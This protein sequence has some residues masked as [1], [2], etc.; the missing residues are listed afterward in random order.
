MLSN[1]PTHARPA[2]AFEQE[3]EDSK[4]SVGGKTA[5]PPKFA[6]TASQKPKYKN[7][8]SL[9]VGPST[10]TLGDFPYRPGEGDTLWTLAEEFYFEPTYWHHI[11]QANKDKCHDDGR[12]IYTQ[13]KLFIPGVEVYMMDTILNNK[14][15]DDRLKYITEVIDKKKYYAVRNT[16]TQFQNE[17]NG[18]TLQRFELF[19]ETSM[20]MKR[21]GKAIYD[22]LDGMA[23][24][25]GKDVYE[26]FILPGPKE[27]PTTRFNRA[28]YGEWKARFEDVVAKLEKEAPKEIQVIIATAKKKAKTEDVFQFEPEECEALS[29]LAFTRSDWKLYVG[30][31]WIEYGEKNIEFL[32]GNVSHELGGHNEY[33]N[34][35]TRELG[36]EVSKYIPQSDWDEM[37]A[38]E[39]NFYQ[40]FGYYE[41][42]IWAELREYE[43]DVNDMLGNG[44]DSNGFDKIYPT[45]F[46][47]MDLRAPIT[48][49]G[50]FVAE[51]NQILPPE[52][53]KAFFKGMYNRAI[54]DKRIHREAV[55][56]FH[57]AILAETK[58]DP[59]K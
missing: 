8:E 5:K 16:L 43:Y 52:I 22:H 34:K 9:P 12:L 26:G 38:N 6:P 56:K 37:T 27:N 13:T 49:I 48:E 14:H 54:N 18:E 17:Q 39:D 31:E 46:P 29:A 40:V 2:H 55:K 11:Y 21:M 1:Q 23:A 35:L 57:A 3:N 30:T 53:S 51:L 58:V 44:P 36:R 15:R 50:Y 45:H 42:E 25:E 28:E 24:T 10:M 32:F 33:G 4:A 19:L 41:T 47:E 59:V 20:D 7:P